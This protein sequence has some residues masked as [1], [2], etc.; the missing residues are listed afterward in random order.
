MSFE[1]DL[2]V[3]A[4]TGVFQILEEQ[5]A[6][7]ELVTVN[8]KNAVCRNLDTQADIPVTNAGNASNPGFTVEVPRGAAV[9]CTIYNR[10]P[11]TLTIEKQILPLESQTPEAAPGWQFTAAG[12][13]VGIMGDTVKTTAG[14]P[15]IVTYPLNFT[16]GDSGSVR[17]DE[18]QQTGFRFLGVTCTDS[19]ANTVTP[20]A[21]ENDGFTVPVTRTQNIHC[22]VQNGPIPEP[23][24]TIEKRVIPVDG[25]TGDS[26]PTEG[27][28]FSAQG[29]DVTPTPQNGEVTGDNG[30]IVYDLDFGNGASGATVT[31]SETQ[32]NGY[33]IYQVND[34]NA[35][36]TDNGNNSLT[37]NNSG[38]LGFTVG[39]MKLT[40]HIH[41]IV[42]NIEVPEPELTIIKQLVPPH[43]SPDVDN[44]LGAGWTFGAT[45]GQGVNPSSGQTDSD[46]EIVF[47]VSLGDAS[48]A[49]V[50]VTE[51][52]QDGYTLMGVVCDGDRVAY[53]N[54]SFTV[55]V[56]Q[57]SDIT[58]VV[59]NIEAPAPN[60]TLAKTGSISD[61]NDN[62]WSDAGDEIT[63][64][65]TLT[66]DGNVPLTNL[67]IHDDLLGDGFALT[68]AG[69]VALADVTLAPGESITCTADAPYVVSGQDM[70]ALRVDN[71]ADATGVD[72]EV[73]GT[74]VRSNKD[75]HTEPL[76][77]PKLTLVKSV[78]EIDDNN[79]NELTDAGDGIWYEFRLTNEGNVA[80]TSLS[81]EDSIL[82]D[83]GIAITCVDA[84]FGNPV[85]LPPGQSVTCEA[86]E[87]YIITLEDMETGMVHNVATAT[88]YDPDNPKETEVPSNESETRTPLDRVAELTLEKSGILEDIADIE[89][90][91]GW[92]D[93]GDYIW[94]SFTLTNTGT[95]PLTNLVIHD[96]LL[97][98]GFAVDC[99]EFSLTEDT[100]DPGD[101]ITCDAIAA[102]V[103]TED[104]ME[105][106]QVDNV[107]YATG[108]DP[109]DE[110][111]PV[112]S[113][114]DEH[115]EYLQLAELTLEKD[116]AEIERN[117]AESL[118]VTGDVIWYSFL[119]T[120]TGNVTLTD[121]QVH[122]AL[123]ASV[124]IEITCVD[125]DL[126]D[127]VVL[128][129]GDSV[130]CLALA[131][132]EITEADMAALEVRNLA[133]AT[134]QDPE[135]EQTHEV[136]SNEDE[137]VTPLDW[138]PD[139]IL[140]KRVTEVVDVNDNG[141][142]DTGDEIWY[143]FELTN[144]GDVRITDLT[145]QDDLLDALGITITCPATEL[146]PG[147]S[148]LCTAD[149][150]YIV[151]ADDLQAGEV[152]NVA[153]ATGTDPEDEPV[154]SNEDDT[155]TPLE[156]EA[157]LLLEK[158]VALIQDINGNG[159]TDA[160]DRLWFG[161]RV[162]NTGEVTITN[163]TVN[164]PL[165]A[166]LGIGVSCA[167]DSLDPG[168]FTLC[169]AD[170]AYVVTAADV[171][172]GQ[173]RN[174][175][176]STGD[177]PSDEPVDSNEDET[178]TP[179][180]E[181]PPGPTPTPTPS[182]T[183]T[184]SVTPTVTPTPSATPSPSPTASPTA[185]PTPRPEDELGEVAPPV[186]PTT[187]PP[188]VPAP[189]KAGM[190]WIANEIPSGLKTPLSAALDWLLG[191]DLGDRIPAP[192]ALV[193]ALMVL[194]GIVRG[195]RGRPETETAT[196]EFRR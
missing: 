82:D 122:D 56:Q 89:G 123:L 164:D 47:T 45:G 133:D 174:V 143:E 132:Y 99:G 57:Q 21:V 86:T 97:G 40:S 44:T 75:D 127:P 190:G 144:A 118:T 80:L 22:V 46:G 1:Y 147:E 49:D 85:V 177:D 141:R 120:N 104:D 66:N 53:E 6:G 103:V 151:T 159:I 131:G 145:V 189:G 154:D 27:W 124:N 96:D 23:T 73:P 152:H 188:S 193:L 162:T 83:A 140:V 139:L 106:L 8:D 180:E 54:N 72:P 88:G 32:Q 168:Q 43:G 24:L 95:V 169:V 185:S 153:T 20:T 30:Q 74:P 94:Y 36:C 196:E 119:L 39:G 176:T 18:A 116:I 93:E 48:S 172:A 113:N 63:Y 2:P 3:E 76:Q 181:T 28:T 41:C 161:F 55:T 71:E 38:D 115:T 178:E 184:P 191:K 92:S 150:P 10:L 137:T 112:E 35:V 4:D 149:A 50:T 192:I 108:I 17:I 14:D 182:P 165:L 26:T 126:G 69:D 9:A 102:Y 51:T 34:L 128:E 155:T 62:G 15:S 91:N 135:N 37:V 7:Y 110:D 175:A 13:G 65:F 107:A 68:C 101:S 130:L 170:E 64:S 187:S 87:A 33:E 158:R 19:Q 61:V 125:E 84:Q 100:L 70:V 167:N 90:G 12:T 25:S 134:A 78:A 67:V 160:G 81:I 142:A 173:V 31:V 156:W 194:E 148:T 42:Y 136:R 138:V 114:I 59:Y 195:T 183:A 179:V 98:D 157:T 166:A 129:P 146:D 111:N 163:V 186:P 29:S 117:T 5:Q 77:A 109:Q 52:P 60:L 121:L 11:P 105:A 16:S 79:D 171:A 58:C